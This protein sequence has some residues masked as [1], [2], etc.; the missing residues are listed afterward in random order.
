MKQQILVI[1]GGHPADTYKKYL[2]H[3]KKAEVSLEDLR[4]K[5]WKANLEKSLGKWYEV[6]SPKMPNPQRAHYEEWKIWFEKFAPLL[7]RDAIL[8]GHSLGGAFLAKYLSEKK[9]PRNLKATFLVAPPFYQKK[10]FKLPKSLKMFSRQGGR[11]FLYQSR[12]DWVVSFR[13]FEKFRKALPEAT[14]RVFHN[15]GHFHQ[16]ELPELVKDIK[17]L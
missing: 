6:L 3:L 1:H 11:V 12:D 13:H 10:S 17:N 16:E 4:F 8:I 7:N 2:L 15:R 9:F 14:V 5:G